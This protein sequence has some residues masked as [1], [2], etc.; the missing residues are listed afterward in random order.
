MKRKK[1]PKRRLFKCV[2]E[3]QALRGVNLYGG[4]KW[5]PLVEGNF[6]HYG[7]KYSLREF[8]KVP[9]SGPEWQQEFDGYHNTDSKAGVVIKLSHDGKMVKAFT[10]TP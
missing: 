10:F 8:A 9:G 2:K 1:T 4:N 5:F 6:T 7:T 3:G